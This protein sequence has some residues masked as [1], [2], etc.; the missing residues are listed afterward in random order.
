MSFAASAASTQEQRSPAPLISIGMPV[1]NVGRWLAQAIESV[2]AQTRSDWELLI[3]DNASTDDTWSIAQHYASADGRIRCRRADSNRGLPANWNIVA[4]AARGRYFKWLSGTDRMAPDLLARGVAVLDTRPEV[5]LVFGRT[6][7][8]DE[9]GLPMSLCELDFPVL[10]ARPVDRFLQVATS[11]SVNNQINASLIRTQA[12]RH[13]RL[14]ADYPSSDLVLMAELAL[15]GPFVMLP[16]EV[17]QR[18][19][20]RNFSTPDRTPLQI[21]RMY[22][23]RARRPRRSQ[24]VRKH[25]G[26][27]AAC[28][29]APIGPADRALAT[30][31]ATHLL[32]QALRRRAASLLT[33]VQSPA[34]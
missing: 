13:T 8:I 29:R 17:Y 18:R 23:P 16:C 32:L 7:W 19:A 9:D 34:V 31:A 6:R 20:G 33:G 21:E 28:W 27:F 5:V 12:L 30:M 4:R 2:Q 3:S 22:N 24:A 25:A 14:L 26:R 1:F 11:L 15:Q 10:A